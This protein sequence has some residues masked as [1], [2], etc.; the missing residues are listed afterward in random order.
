MNRRL[1]RCRENRMLAGVAAGVAEYFELDPSLVRILWFLSIF[2]GGIGIL[3]YVGLAIIIPNEPY[4]VTRPLAG[5]VE[6]TEGEIPAA[7]SLPG[8]AHNHPMVAAQGHSHAGGTGRISMFIG[9]A[10]ILFGSIALL[11]IALPDWVSWRQL[12]PVF[13]IG[14][15]GLLIAGALRRERESTE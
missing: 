3:L 14:I 13:I 7:G 8:A 15:G 6:G 9:A 2:I 5:A 12:W 11:D 10:L 4:G 1:Y